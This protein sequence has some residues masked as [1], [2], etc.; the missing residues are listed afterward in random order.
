MPENRTIDGSNNNLENPTWG[1]ANEPLIRNTTPAYEGLNGPSGSNRPNPKRISDIVCAQGNKSI[2]N[3]KGLSDYMWAW[4]Q[5]LDH[6]I[7]LSPEDMREEFPIELPDGGSIPFARSEYDESTGTG[8]GN[9]RQQTNVLSAFVD[10][11]NVYGADPA[12]AAVLRTFDG[13]GKLLV[14]KNN[15][16]PK[17]PGGLPNVNPPNLPAKNFFVAG[18]VRANEHVV[19]MCLHTLFVREH[20]RLCDELRNKMEEE[21]KR[22]S[23]TEG[24][25]GT[26]RR[27]GAVFNVDEQI[28]QH[29]RKIVG[30]LMQAI[31][32]NEFLP[33]LLGGHA[34]RPYTGYNQNVDASIANI[35][36]TAAYRLGHSML[37]PLVQRVGRNLKP[38]KFEETFFQP[39]L[40]EK[41]GIEP[42]LAGAAAQPMQKIDAKAIDSIRLMLFKK[43]LGAFDPP[44]LDLAALNIQRGRDHGLPDYNSCRE[45]YG[46][47]PKEDFR[48]ISS[49]PDMQDRLEHAYRGD[50]SLIDP[51]I[52]GLA[53][54][55]HNGAIVG[56]FFFHV[57]KDQFER[58]RDGDRFWYENDL[59]L[60]DDEREEIRNT[61]LSDVIK[62]NTNI[63]NLQKN[64]FEAKPAT[65]TLKKSRPAKK[66]TA[67]KTK[68]KST[69]R[70]S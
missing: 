41:D 61:K 3:E 18:D 10:A 31:T 60:S 17:N 19:L 36:S 37:S 30:G 59:G 8:I 32:Y 34:L 24:G 43:P 38:I 64:V 15:L 67:R 53:E 14:G 47:E 11:S 48:D 22:K 45:S 44:P 54:D 25:K 56:E 6:E 29:A 68:K 40:V 7:D 4:G 35:F 42:Y 69:R 58:L 13:S 12:R 16:L 21:A 23:E 63:R 5:F 57:L 27:A 39:E 49:D 33:A 50:V 46:L 2:E 26:Y 66:K 28:Y 52:G 70:K 9:P 62:R 65:N 20:N 51:W 55:H 1:K